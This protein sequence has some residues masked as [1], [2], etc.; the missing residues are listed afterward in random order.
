MRMRNNC[1][2]AAG[3]ALA[4]AYAYACTSFF[5]FFIRPGTSCKICNV[6][7]GYAV[8]TG[9]MCMFLGV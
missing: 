7:L 8:R 5:L 9:D 6:A 3:Q 1:V 2:F 4:C